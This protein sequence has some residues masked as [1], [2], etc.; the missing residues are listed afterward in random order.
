MEIKLSPHSRRFF[1]LF[2]AEDSHF[3]DQKKKVGE[4]AFPFLLCM[5]E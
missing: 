3:N 5:I 1:I 2:R 4:C